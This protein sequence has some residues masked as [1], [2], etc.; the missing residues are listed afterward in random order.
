LTNTY[1]Q[2]NGFSSFLA[3]ATG[4]V[5]HF[6]LL[7]GTPATNAD[8]RRLASA[9][10]RKLVSPEVLAPVDWLFLAPDTNTFSIPMDGLELA[11]ARNSIASL[12]SGLAFDWSDKMFPKHSWPWTAARESAFVM[13]NQGRYT[14]VELERLY[15]SEET[16]PIGFLAIAHLL[17]AADS[18]TAKDFA[19]Q[20]LTRLGAEH[21]LADCNLFLRGDSGLARSFARLVEVLRTLPDNELAALAAVLP[22]SEADLLR[23]SATALRTKPEATPG[24]A[25]S[26]AIAKY[27]Q[28]TLRTKV[29][30]ALYQLT[31]QPK[32]SS[33]RT[34]SRPDVNQHQPPGI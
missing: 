12:F 23:E 9:A 27:W 2:G 10:V 8:Q 22:E 5:A 11:M 17:R 19:L 18:P 26:P 30:M 25:L 29:Q 28:Q 13:M 20:G 15:R 16:G 1:S 14:D 3:L 32:G 33:G 24:S 6:Y 21:F 7:E 34:A 4:E 31:T